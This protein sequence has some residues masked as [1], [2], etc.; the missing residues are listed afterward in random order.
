MT[1][2]TASR[3]TIS[4]DEIARVVELEHELQRTLPDIDPQ[5][6]RHC[7][8]GVW[9]RFK[10]ATVRDFVPLLVRREVV[11]QLRLSHSSAPESLTAD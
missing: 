2:R 3:T 1:V 6:I 10:D 4:G 7:V 8:G 9:A 5:R 11:A